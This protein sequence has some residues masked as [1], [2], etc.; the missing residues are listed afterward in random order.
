MKRK[1]DA[2]PE[3]SLYPSAPRNPSELD[4]ELRRFVDMKTPYQPSNPEEHVIDII[5]KAHAPTPPVE[6]E[7]GNYHWLPDGQKT[8]RGRWSQEVSFH[9]VMN[10]RFTPTFL[11]EEL[12]I[13]VRQATQF[14]AR[15]DT[16]LGPTRLVHPDPENGVPRAGQ[17][18]SRRA[19]H[20]H[21]LGRRVVLPLRGLS[22]DGRAPRVS[23]Q[24]FHSSVALMV[25]DSRTDHIGRRR[26]GPTIDPTSR[27]TGSQK[28]D[29]YFHLRLQAYAWVTSGLSASVIWHGMPGSR[30]RRAVRMEK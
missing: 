30:V 18:P 15:R 10:L 20:Q 13:K 28:C 5:S 1:G 8:D 16:D 29:L 3:K 26:R 9:S 11:T 4:F 24:R 14:E 17:R 2:A 12:K 27:A 7:V 23:V 19:A 6:V 21:R 25:I 22:T